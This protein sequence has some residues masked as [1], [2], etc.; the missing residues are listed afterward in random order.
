MTLFIAWGM[1]GCGTS[2]EREE[3]ARAQSEHNWAIMMGLAAAVAV[4]VFWVKSATSKRRLQSRRIEIEAELQ[5][6]RNLLADRRR[7]L[8][9]IRSEI[10]GVEKESLI[11]N[12]AQI[13]K[14]S[15]AISRLERRLTNLQ[16]GRGYD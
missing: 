1:V 6:L 11:S 15:D 13:Q 7:E 9:Q 12:E 14:Q 2:A 4:L 16:S 5:P 10:V 3:L 8:E